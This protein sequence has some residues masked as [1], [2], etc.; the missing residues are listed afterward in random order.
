MSTTSQ[1]LEIDTPDGV[2]DAYLALP[3]GG[4][5]PGIVLLQEIFGVNEHIRNLADQYAA[6]GYIVLAPDLFWRSA[7]RTE[8]GYDDESWKTAYKLMQLTDVEK[9]LADIGRTA[10]TLRVWTGEGSRIAALGYCFGGRLAYLAAARGLSD[11]AVAYYG[12]GIQD[13]LDVAAQLAVPLQLHFGGRDEHI[14]P[15]A[16]ASV[17][18]CFA[19]QRD[20]EIHVYPGAGHGFNCPHRHNYV[21]RMAAQAHG[22]TLVFLAEHL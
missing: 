1:W 2:F 19:D 7:T 18:E 14:P 8:L 4:K 16:V 10:A 15:A 12:G 17:A 22:N 3:H 11:A 21:Q 13:R 9:A 6:D 20:V 5:G